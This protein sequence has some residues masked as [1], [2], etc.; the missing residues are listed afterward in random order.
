[1]LYAVLASFVF[2]RTDA[3]FF[4]L[5]LEVHAIICYTTGDTARRACHF[6]PRPIKNELSITHKDVIIH[7]VHSYIQQNIRHPQNPQGRV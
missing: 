3:S 4:Q 2:E 7:H 5:K 1:M 6:H